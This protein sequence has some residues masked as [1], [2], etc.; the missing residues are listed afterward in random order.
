MEKEYNDLGNIV[1]DDMQYSKTPPTPSDYMSK[2]MEELG[3]FATEVNKLTGRKTNKNGESDAVIQQRLINEAMDATQCIF[4]ILI[5]LG[6][7]YQA[8]PPALRESNTNF[9]AYTDKKKALVAN[10]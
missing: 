1:L 5:L 2:L 10:K 8:L 3:E 9:K 6:I 7:N 4:G